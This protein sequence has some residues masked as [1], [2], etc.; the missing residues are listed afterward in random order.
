M[1]ATLCAIDSALN[2]A[3]IVFKALILN[4][5]YLFQKHI[6]DLDNVYVQAR[7]AFTKQMDT[8]MNNY[9]IILDDTK[10]YSAKNTAALN[11]INATVNNRSFTAD[12][13]TFLIMVLNIVREEADLSDLNK[14]EL[15]SLHANWNRDYDST[16]I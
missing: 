13:E 4:D 1:A 16:T 10:L 7:A 11:I 15:T 8:V 9:K 5:E 14:S 3:A 6:V 12:S 2:I